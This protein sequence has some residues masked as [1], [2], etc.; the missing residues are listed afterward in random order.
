M[1]LK[2][3]SQSLGLSQTTVSRALNGYPEV[4]EATRQRV[5][6]AALENNYSPN[7]RAKG[8]ATGRAMS[9]A[10]VIPLSNQH[11]MVNP[12]FG[13]FI[14]GAGEIY[15]QNG[16]DMLLSIVSD[17]DEERAY[18]QI[19]ARG[20]VDGVIIHGPRRDDPRIDLLRD[21]G[22]PFVVHGRA[23]DQPDT[24]S[25]IDVNNRRAFERATGLLLDLG[26]RRI[27]FLNGLEKMDFAMRRRSGYEAALSSFGISPEPD[28]MFSEEMTEQYGHRV[29][30]KVLASPNPPTAFLAS[31]L[32]TTFGIRR[33]VEEAELV[34]GRDVSIVTHDDAL[35]YIQN[36]DVVPIYTATRSSVRE[37]GRLAATQLLDMIAHPQ[38]AVKSQLLEAELVLGQSTGPAPS[39]AA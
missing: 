38:S 16:Y 7:S 4:N 37:A 27:A 21:L 33:A 9:I 29:A 28:L 2:E 31:S 25:W 17:T 23:S 36:G 39:S 18:R 5:E 30:S 32:I 14:S 20:A 10:H 19:K 26:H 24:Y 22:L 12:V 3:L 8:L 15:S 34:V 13:D 35:S 6:K 1:N 11:E